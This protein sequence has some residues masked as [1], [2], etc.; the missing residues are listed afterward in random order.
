MLFKFNKNKCKSVCCVVVVV[1]CQFE[2]DDKFYRYNSYINI[3]IYINYITDTWQQ[4][5]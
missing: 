4:Q 1:N 5:K 3:Y 2:L